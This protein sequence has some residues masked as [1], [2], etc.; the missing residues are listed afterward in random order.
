M[1]KMQTVI[2]HSWFER[3][4]CIGG[5]CPMTCC[6]AYGWGI[7]LLDEEIEIYKEIEGEIGEEIRRSINYDR[8]RFKCRGEV[9]GDQSENWYKCPLLN[10]KGWCKIV[11]T[12]GEEMLSQT[13]Q[14]Y[15]RHLTALNNHFE[16]YVDISCRWLQNTC[17]MTCQ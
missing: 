9:Y 17:L 14:L 7:A 10:E 11:L 1:E 6:N 16:Q 3:F 15:P 8:K 13:C 5:T 2:N 4:S 12:C